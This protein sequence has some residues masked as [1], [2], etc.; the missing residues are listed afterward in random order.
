M[1]RGK[2][3]PGKGTHPHRARAGQS[4]PGT[5]RRPAGA[6]TAKKTCK[7][8][9]EERA[10]PR[11]RRDGASGR[12]GPDDRQTLS[13]DMTHPVGSRLPALSWIG[14]V[15]ICVA[16]SCCGRS[17]EEATISKPPLLLAACCG[18]WNR[19]AAGAPRVKHAPHSGRA[20]G[21]NTSRTYLQ[22]FCNSPSG[23]CIR[24]D[25]CN[26]P[27]WIGVVQGCRRVIA[28]PARILSGCRG[29]QRPPRTLDQVQG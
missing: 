18:V 20:M 2:R 9:N 16:G 23:E 10:A 25:R 21:C 29:G 6:G 13:R 28:A 22:I 12:S 15:N 3:G 4:D 14:D 24:D 26:S 5:G 11:G 8:S 17:I 7:D 27:G 19:R 1:R